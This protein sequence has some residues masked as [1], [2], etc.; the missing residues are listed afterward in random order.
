MNNLIPT[1]VVWQGSVWFCSKH[2]P[3]KYLGDPL[4]V[5]KILSDFGVDEIAIMNLDEGI[6]DVIYEMPKYVTRPLSITGGISSFDNAKKLI[7][8]GFDRL[9]FT[10][11][12]I[13]ESPVFEKVFGYFGTSTLVI[14]VRTSPKVMRDVASQII[15]QYPA[16]EYVFHDVEQAGTLKGLR[17]N[18]QTLALECT[19]VNIAVSGGYNG[20]AAPKMTRV[21]YSSKSVFPLRE[22]PFD[23]E[24]DGIPSDFILIPSGVVI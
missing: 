1:V 7:G 10:D 20:G 9:G 15:R 18:F 19:G 6:S 24:N 3:I 14:N 2:K 11:P 5:V 12:H 17:P 22:K 16:S 4:N 23:F 21:Y 13:V 8:S